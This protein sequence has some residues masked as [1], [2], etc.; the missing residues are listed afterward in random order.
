MHHNDVP[1][2]DPRNDITDL[3]VFRAPDDPTSSI[4][5]LNVYP[6]ASMAA[7]AIDPQASYELKIDTDGDLEAEVAFHVLFASDDL[8]QQTAKVYRASGAEARESGPIGEVIIHHAPVSVEPKLHITTAGGYR[9]F[10]GLRSDPFFADRI[11]FANKMQW[12]GQD[13][14]ADENVFGIVLTVPNSVLGANGQLNLWARTIG[15]GAWHVHPS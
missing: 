7:N 6:E 15:A 1:E 8:G 9:F 10:A 13:Y 14:F 11:G 4:L 2:G 12:T 3:Y 5:I